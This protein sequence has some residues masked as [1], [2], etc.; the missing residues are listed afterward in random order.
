MQIVTV[1][2]DH[3]DAKKLD[4]E[5]QLEYVWRYGDEGDITPLDPEMFAPPRGIYLLVYDEGVPV[6][7]GA[8]RGLER[9]E[10]G[11]EDGDAEIKRM[12]VVPAARGRGLARQILARLED[13]ARAAGRIRMVL[14]TGTAQPEAMELYR[15]SG[16]TPAP[17]KFG[18][19]RFEEESRCFTKDLTGT[20]PRA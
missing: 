8:W 3:P 15:S 2:Y 12:Y 7:S 11:Y 9:N 10:E 13:D 4:A 16:Y 17:R 18:I 20:T 19:F 14:E 1:R 6:A 5:V